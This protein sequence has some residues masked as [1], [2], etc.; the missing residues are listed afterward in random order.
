VSEPPRDSNGARPIPRPA[1]RII[2]LDEAD[3]VLLFRWMLPPANPG[4][5]ERTF[6]ITPG[7]GVQPGESPEDAARRE[8]WEETGL[9]GVPIGACV[10]TR[11][12]VFAWQG[13]LI[14]QQERYFLARLE[15]APELTRDN[16][17]EYEK[18]ALAEHRWW[19]L[20]AIAT[21]PERFV[22]QELAVL[23]PAVIR[24]ELPESPLVVR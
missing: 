8:L 9:S 4:E 5:A 11:N 3:R 10:W 19:P 20:D 13:R 18:T 23:R 6:W 2:L 24:G 21:S 16:F 14:E 15:A 22:P 12:V 17:E 1:S 7:G